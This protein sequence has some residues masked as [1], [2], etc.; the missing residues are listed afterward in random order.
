MKN[1]ITLFFIG[2]FFAFFFVFSANAQQKTAEEIVLRVEGE[3]TLE[4][5]LSDLAKMPRSKTKIISEKL[6]AEFEGVELREILKLAGA[7]IGGG[8]LRGAELTKYLLV[9]AADGYKAVFALAE[10]DAEFTGKS[11][12][13]ADTRDGKPL[14][15]GEGRLRLVVSDDKKQGRWVRQIIKISI[16][17]AQ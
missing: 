13:L 2:F 11:I 8:Q 17:N 9:E 14:A 16:K 4:L 3:K 15:G 6:N 10:I 7:K 1:F 12:L 5:K